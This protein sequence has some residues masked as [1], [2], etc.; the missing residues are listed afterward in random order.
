MTAHR[1]PSPGG[2]PVLVRRLVVAMVLSL[3]VAGCTVGGSVQPSI[4]GP[5]TAL[6]VGLGYIPSVQF[7][8]FYLAD[9]AGYY[10]AAGLSVT[11]Q[12]QIDPNLVTLVGQGSIDI[13]LSDGTSVVPAASQGIPI[14]YLATVYGTFPSI[15]FAKASSGI[16]AAADLKSKRIGIPGRYGSSWVMLQ[17]L[18]GSAKLT[19][20]DVTIVEYPDFGQGAGLQ[21]GQVDAAT[22]F[23]NNEPVQ[24]RLSG[25]PVNVLRIDQVIHLPGPGFITGTATLDRKRAALSAFIAATIK[26]MREIAANP[27]KGLDATV[28]AVPDLLST[29]SR[30]TQAA[31]LDATIADWS[32]PGG[33]PATYGAI[34]R[35]GWQA[36]IDYLGTLG[37]VPKPVTVDQVIEDLSAAT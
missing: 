20:D 10:S 28:A 19:P 35:P 31:I 2:R 27:T 24:A 16:A 21:Q 1:L 26:A 34:D 32:A 8:P 29:G 25:T 7:A 33:S 37:M 4:S 5:K 6:V 18:L 9:Q 30:A 36:T 12:N 14:K 3:L 15:V 13:G 11:F 22:G 23:D 17:A